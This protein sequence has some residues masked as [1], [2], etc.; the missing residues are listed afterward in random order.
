MVRALNRFTAGT[1]PIS[2][3]QLDGMSNHGAD[4]TGAEVNW[5]GFQAC[6]KTW[7]GTASYNNS[8]SNRSNNAVIVCGLR[9]VVAWIAWMSW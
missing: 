4:R 3:M 1:C 2:T 6:I 9:S 5:Q 7:K 8:E